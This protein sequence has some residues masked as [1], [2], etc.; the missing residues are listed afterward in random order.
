MFVSTRGQAPAVALD[1]ALRHGLAPDGGLYVPTA[2]PRLTADEWA[3]LRGRSLPE[4]ATALVAPLVADTFDVATLGRLMMSALS[5]PIPLVPIVPGTWALELFHGPTLAFKDIGARTMARWLAATAGAAGNGPLTV[6]V[7]TSGDTGGA[8][9]HA[10]HGVAGTRVV[11]LYPR[12]RVSAVQEAQFATLGGNV[13]AVAVDGTFDDCQ[14]LV[15]EAFSDAALAA[16]Q[17]LT[18]ANSISVGRL[19]P[20][21]AYY[22]WAAL[23]LPADAAPPVVVVPSGNLGNLTAGLLAVRRGVPI[24]RF[25]AATTVND[26]LPRYLASG[27]YEPRAAV[28]TLA[29]AMDVGYPS[30]FER[31]QWLFDGDVDAMRESVVGLTVSDDDIRTAIRDMDAR[32]YLADPHTAVGW[33]GAAASAAWAAADVPRVVLSTAHPAKFGDVVAPII[34]RDVPLPPAL[35]ERMAEPPRPL[36]A[37]P[38]LAAVV[39]ILDRLTS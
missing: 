31:L 38:E 34:G 12:G 20:Q 5:F 26:P 1:V 6:L 13:T 4:V 29:N 24:G 15:K 19:L 39:A 11:V 18:S 33:V 37:A 22:A 2:I 25:V 32:G 3:G 21:M 10:F 30:N 16:R 14:R 17:R 36:P 23:Q 9:A 35:A 7:A 8:V 27:R 28:A